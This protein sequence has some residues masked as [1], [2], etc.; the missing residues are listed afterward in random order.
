MGAASGGQLDTDSILVAAALIRQVDYP[1]KLVWTR[2]EDL[3]HDYYRP[4]Y[5]DRVSAGL[6]AEGR[7]VGRTHRVTGSSVYARWAP[8]AFK[9]GLDIDAVDCTA[10]TPYDMA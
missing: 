7:I 1:V 9:N 5:Y 3:R 8:A 10:E 2:E 6:D 4:Y